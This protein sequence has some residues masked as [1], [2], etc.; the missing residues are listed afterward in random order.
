[1]HFPPREF[2]GIG[3]F[4]AAYTQYAL[5]NFHFYEFAP[6]GD[7]NPASEPEEHRLSTGGVLTPKIA[8]EFL[9]H[10]GRRDPR[11]KERVERL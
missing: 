5:V 6:S 7:S 9:N 3:Q 11:L 8:I 2:G 1:M 10:E 4:S